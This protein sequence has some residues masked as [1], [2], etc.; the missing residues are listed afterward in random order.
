[1]K[2][3]KTNLRRFLAMFLLKGTILRVPMSEDEVEFVVVAALV[4]PEH[5]GVRGLVVELAEIG[6]S[7]GTSG[8][9]LNVRATAVLAF[10]EV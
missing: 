1:M 3:L 10:L 6:L 7:I 5:D 8:E 2:N 4:G 9:E